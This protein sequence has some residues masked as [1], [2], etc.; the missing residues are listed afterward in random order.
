MRRV[1]EIRRL[2]R[3]S[4]PSFDR[5]L[6]SGVGGRR[7][8]VGHLPA[9]NLVAGEALRPQRDDAAQH[10]RYW[11]AVGAGGAVV[12]ASVA[13]K[14]ARCEDKATRS[15]VVAKVDSFP[16]G[17]LRQIKV[18]PVPG[19]NSG[20]TIMVARIDGKFYATGASCS[21]YSAPLAE[22]VASKDRMHVVCPWHDA[23]FDIRTGQPVRGPALQAIPT[24][25]TSV[26]NGQVIVELP[27]EMEDFVLPKA[28]RRSPDDPRTFVVVGGGGAGVTAAEALRQEGFTGRIVM[29]SEEKH[30]PYD[31]PMLSKNIAKAAEPAS[32]SLRDQDFFEAHDIE[33]RLSTRVAGLD[34]EN[35]SIKLA[36]GE[37]L[38]Y[39]C[40][41]VATGAR[42]RT[43]QVPGGNLPNVFV[44]RSPEDATAIAA[45]CT[46][47][48][49][50]V[51][52]GSSFIGME[53]A[54]TLRRRGCEV[55]VLGMEAVPFERVLGRRVGASMKSFFESKG[56]EIIGEAILSEIRSKGSGGMEAVLKSG[57]VLPCDCV[58][59]GVGV[60]P[61]AGFV[62]G[63]ETARD[64]SLTTDEY[65]QTSA[66]GLFAAGD[67][68]RYKSPHSGQSVRS[69]HWDVAMS[70]GRIAARNMVGKKE[71]YDVT[72]FFWTSIFGK[73][74]RYVGHCMKFDEI[75]VDGDIPKLN[76]VIYYCFEGAI[77]AV[78]T[79]GRDP[80][81]VTVAEL[82]RMRKMP[83]AEALKVGDSPTT[84]LMAELKKLNVAVATP[85]SGS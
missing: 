25:P 82:M 42:P 72:P 74:L 38:R 65:L 39:D 69:E 85:G 8:A 66:E 54:A 26:E 23:A 63:A 6:A 51:V 55:V 59:V 18:P 24:Y 33:V 13:W 84:N 12:S 28:V 5:A 58:V 60:I 3:R 35:R 71:A 79:M 53:T 64:G 17:E 77:L 80:V 14:A 32:L 21:H 30:L 22:G 76:F 10:W 36:S 49:R 44:L 62:S 81:A 16:D 57:K 45:E 34:A 52:V 2:L 1:H 43:L 20:D 73:N 67:L 15:V 75:I 68:A 50:V 27:R 47:G 70:Q 19:M 56:V 41:L 31:R 9:S 11:I 83:T 40:A 4:L 48:K 78:A 46:A 37:V 61:N 7:V 29:L